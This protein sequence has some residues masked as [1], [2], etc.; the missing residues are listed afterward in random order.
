MIYADEASGPLADPSFRERC[1]LR[2]GAGVA[3]CPRAANRWLRLVYLQRQ[4]KP[5]VRSHDGA[6]PPISIR[7]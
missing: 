1:P 4:C 2:K 3:F 6:M 5:Y 7:A